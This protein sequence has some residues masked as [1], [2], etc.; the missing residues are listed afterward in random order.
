M[1][2]SVHYAYIVLSVFYLCV[3]SLCLYLRYRLMI[4]ATTKTV[5]S[6]IIW[7]YNTYKT[8]KITPSHVSFI[9][10]VFIRTLLYLFYVYKFYMYTYNDMLQT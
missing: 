3:Y 10:M 5:Y 9:R 4:T 6:R 8:A 7:A 1:Y 2:V